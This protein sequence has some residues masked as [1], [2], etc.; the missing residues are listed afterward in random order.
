MYCISNA[1]CQFIPQL[2]NSNIIKFHTSLQE[3]KSE[4][5]K[6]LIMWNNIEFTHN[7]YVDLSYSNIW[8]D[9]ALCNYWFNSEN[10]KSIYHTVLNVSSPPVLGR[11]NFKEF[12]NNN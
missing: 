8:I 5:A 11:T 7:M 10:N 9:I 3:I 1:K 4:W 2:F 6:L 12:F